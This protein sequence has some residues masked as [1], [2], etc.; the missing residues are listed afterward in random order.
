MRSFSTTSLI[1]ALRTSTI[2]YRLLEVADGQ[3]G[4]DRRRRADLQDDAGLHVGAE[5]LQRHFQ[6][7]RARGQVRQRIAARTVGDRRARETGVG[8]RH[9]DADARQHGA[10]FIGNAT[11]QL[12]GRLC[13]CG[14]GCQ[15]RNRRADENNA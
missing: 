12:G 4:V 9:R 7:V 5:S 3:R 15:K 11:V 2:G 1:P 14:R 10:A 8:L 13:R 6:A